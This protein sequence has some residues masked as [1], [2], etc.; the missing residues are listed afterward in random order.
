ML[1]RDSDRRD[2]A[3]AGK[4]MSCQYGLALGGERQESCEVE[5]IEGKE[6]ATHCQSRPRP[7]VLPITASVET[8][9]SFGELL[10][11]PSS[12]AERSRREEAQRTVAHEPAAL[13]AAEPACACRHARCTR[14][15]HVDLAPIATCRLDD[16]A[17]GRERVSQ[18]VRGAKEEEEEEE[19]ER[20]H[21]KRSPQCMR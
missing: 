8:C 21:E 19:G 1:R 7:S 6:R 15:A 10:I 9:V 14:R 11:R 16:A 4:V 12:T 20:T 3:A 17:G 13:A 5:R 18:R 2:V